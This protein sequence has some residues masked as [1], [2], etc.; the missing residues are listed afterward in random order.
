VTGVAGHTGIGHMR[1]PSAIDVHGHLQHAACHEFG[2]EIVG[3]E[4]AISVTIITT[5]LGRYPLSHCRHESCEL[6]YAQ[7]TKHLH[8]L[9]YR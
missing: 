9:V 7:I 5:L 3:L 2:V 8:I 6:A 4:I 1:L